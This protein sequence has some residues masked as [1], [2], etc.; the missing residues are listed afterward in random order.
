M[1]NDI[2]LKDNRFIINFTYDIKVAFIPISPIIIYWIQFIIATNITSI[3]YCNIS[4]NCKFTFFYNFTSL[5]TSAF[6]KI[7]VLILYINFIIKI[8]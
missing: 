3:R 6:N 4:L 5:K 8:I 2:T 7:Y 1:I